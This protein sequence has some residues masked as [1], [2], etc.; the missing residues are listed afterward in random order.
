MPDGGSSG[1][2][3]VS[4]SSGNVY[5]TSGGG[6]TSDGGSTPVSSPS[7]NVNIET[8]SAPVNLISSLINP[9]LIPEE[10]PGS[11]SASY[12]AWLGRRLSRLSER[13]AKL[14]A[15]Q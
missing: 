9:T 4:D 1:S 5:V 12:N 6:T 13:V 15:A 14:E 8:T 10:R 7:S 11:A 3:Q 2:T